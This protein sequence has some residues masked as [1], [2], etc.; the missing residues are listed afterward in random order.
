MVGLPATDVDG[1]PLTY[2]IV[3]APDAR[4]PIG[5]GQQPHATR[6]RPNY[7][8][9]DSFT[10]K[11]NDGT[12]DSNVAM[13]SLTV[14]PV[15][16]PPVAVNDTATVAEDD[17]IDVDVRAQRL[18]SRRRPADRDRGRHTRARHGRHPGRQRPLHARARTTTA[19]TASRTRSPTGTAAPTLASVALTVTPV[20]DPPVAADSS[21]QSWRR[22]RPRTSRST[23]PTST[24]TRSRT[25]IVTQPQHGTLSG[26]G[27]TRTYTP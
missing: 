23:R 14:L 22:T 20:N 9:P 7:N 13:V 6:R 27:S 15:N 21:A 5:L 18:G 17:F 3:T 26:S 2:S 4:R 8:G 11:A 19:A 1:D 10:F 25:S 16:D 24:A 12:A